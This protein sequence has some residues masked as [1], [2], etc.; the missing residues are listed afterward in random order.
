MDRVKIDVNAKLPIPKC[1]KDIRSFLGQ[2]D[3]YQSFI[4]NFSK[5]AKP[6]TNILAK[7]VPF[8]FDNEFLNSRE[9]HKKELIS[10]PD[11]PKPFKIMYDASNFVI[12]AVLG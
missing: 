3:F 9:T 1:V 8:T 5:I 2:T 7:D 10:A 11:W 12:G 4:K 6:L